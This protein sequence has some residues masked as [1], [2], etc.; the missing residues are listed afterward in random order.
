MPSH[1]VLGTGAVGAAL[2]HNLAAQGR[3]VRAVNRSGKRGS[4]H[5]AIPLSRA[6]LSD[7]AS[8]ASALT[9]ADVVYQ[10]TQPA[11]NRWEEEF[12]ELQRSIL[13]AAA[14]VG[15]RVVLADNLYGYSKPLGNTIT[16]SSPREATTRKGKVRIAMADEALAAHAHGRVQVALTR[17]SNYV[18]ADYKLFRN[19]VLGQISRG[20]PARVLGRTDQPHSFSYA[21]D[22]AL[23]M[24]AIGTSEHGWGRAW[25]TPVMTPI[26]QAEMVARLWE[27]L[28]QR[29]EPKVSALRGIT[30]RGLGIF[31]PLLRESEE[32]MYEFDEPFIVSS[33]EFEQAF[34]F[35][36]TSWDDAVVQMAEAVKD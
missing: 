22:A 20:R 14:R 19:L 34:G 16:D 2:A 32:M 27:A 9:G 7:P 1:V 29:G 10:V 21:P 3:K 26:T 28:G 13:A 5:P 33:A 12:P 30:L 8:A 36:A 4:L 15:A 17:P 24:A 31:M 25:I 11:Y 18:G 23:A 6:N 35:G